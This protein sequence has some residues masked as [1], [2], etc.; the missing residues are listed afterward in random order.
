VSALTPE[1]AVAYVRELTAGSLAV[2]VRDAGGAALAGD[3]ARDAGELVLVRGGDYEIAV[4]I[5]PRALPALARHDADGAL[6]ALVSA[7]DDA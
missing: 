4:S 2:S 6:A 7:G 3:D 5:G 1:L